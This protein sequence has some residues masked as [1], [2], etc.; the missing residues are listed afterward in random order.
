M[1]NIFKSKFLRDFK[2]LSEEFSSA[3]GE[4]DRMQEIIQK[5]LELCAAYKPLIT[6][7]Q[8][9]VEVVSIITNLMT[10]L[11]VLKITGDLQNDVAKLTTRIDELEEKV[12]RIAD[13]RSE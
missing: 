5:Q 10:K 2:T 9:S 6:N 1:D 11:W 8:E 4:N 12:S 13:D 7:K 3:Y